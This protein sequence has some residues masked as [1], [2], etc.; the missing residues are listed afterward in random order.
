ML[1]FSSQQLHTY[2]GYETELFGRQYTEVIED[3]RGKHTALRYDH[4]GAAGRWAP[5]RLQSG[6]AL[7][8]PQALY[9][10]LE[11]SVVE[12]ELARMS[13]K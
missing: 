11:E 4:T 9:I 12:E 5:S 1:P 3:V 8:K 2:L 10:K 6:Q 13:D 7:Q